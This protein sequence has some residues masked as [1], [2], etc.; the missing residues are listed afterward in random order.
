M[1]HENA[2]TL[3]ETVNGNPLGS[4]RGHKQGVWSIAF[5]ADGKTIASSGG[6]GNIRLWNVETRSELLKIEGRSRAV[7]KILFSPDQRTLVVSS[8]GFVLKPGMTIL[9]SH[10]TGEDAPANSHK[11]D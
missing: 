5:S 2:I 8:P 7:S 10:S 3:W 9:R 4:L 11:D 1:D 6:A